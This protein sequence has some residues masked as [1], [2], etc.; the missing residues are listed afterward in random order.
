MRQ[1]SLRIASFSF[2][3]LLILSGCS[4][5][6][7]SAGSIVSADGSTI[8]VIGTGSGSTAE[9]LP[10]APKPAAYA[11]GGTRRQ[12]TERFALDEGKPKPAAEQPVQVAQGVQATP[13]AAP[14]PA[15]PAPV[16]VAAMPTPMY[17]P[18]ASDPDATVIIGGDGNVTVD[19]SVMVAYQ[20]LSGGGIQ[21]LS[22]YN[23]AGAS[24]STLVATIQFADGSASLNGEDRAIL[25][26]VIALQRQYGGALR[27]VGHASA[28]TGDMS[29]ERHDRANQAISESR[30]QSVSRALV[31]LGASR[32]M[33]YAGALGDT[34]PL[35]AEAMPSGEAGNRRAE[36][37]LDY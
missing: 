17:D 24:V 26:Q 23:P 35:Y 1:R 16:P 19:P 30:A 21:P 22:A 29:W 34:Q 7:D 27:V 10:A 37:Y 36:I 4:S 28:R 11:E 18:V 3:A 13:V 15:E 12:P 25:R 6:S 9:G 2:A 14:P 31:S 8:P 20:P 5:D 33:V 32:N